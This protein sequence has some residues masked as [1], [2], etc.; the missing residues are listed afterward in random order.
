MSLNAWLSST[1]SAAWRS[2]SMRWPGASGSTRRIS[3]VSRSSGPNTR[4]KASRLM[5]STPA[6][7]IARTASSPALIR[8]L[9]VAGESASTA[10]AATRRAALTAKTRQSRDTCS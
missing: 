5:T 7:P 1:T 10:T 2:I 3:A 9:T 6:T 4:R 8:E